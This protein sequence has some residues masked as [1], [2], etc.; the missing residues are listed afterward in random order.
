MRKYFD[1][2]RNYEQM[3]GSFQ[4]Y[5]YDF[6]KNERVYS[7]LTG[8]VPTQDEVLFASYGHERAYSG[9]AVV[10]FEKDGEL[11][12]AT[13]SHC[14]CNGLEDQWG[15]RRVTWAALALR[16][17][18]MIKHLDVDGENNDGPMGAH[19]KTSREAFIKLV[20][21]HISGQ[22]DLDRYNA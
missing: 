21:N 10:I 12:E 3:I 18:E 7:G 16:L 5:N 20:Q 11:Y 4:D 17:P 2:F 8:I 19:S 14:S 15:P 6:E 22:A 9:H 13:G 1:S